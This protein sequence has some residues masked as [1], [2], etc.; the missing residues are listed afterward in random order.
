MNNLIGEPFFWYPCRIVI[1]CGVTGALHFR[2]NEIPELLLN[3]SHAVITDWLLLFQSPW[4]KLNKRS[5]YRVWRS[6]VWSNRPLGIR[7]M[8]LFF[9][10]LKLPIYI[11]IYKSQNWRSPSNLSQEYAIIEVERLHHFEVGTL[12]I[13]NRRSRKS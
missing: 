6:C 1:V 2:F 8:L 4:W 11:C 3:A 13:R 5:T 12:L 9:K 10:D 7:D